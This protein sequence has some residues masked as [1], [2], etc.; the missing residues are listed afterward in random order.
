MIYYAAWLTS[1]VTALDVNVETVG[2]RGSSA[3]RCID[4]LATLQNESALLRSNFVVSSDK[5]RTCLNNGVVNER[6]N[7]IQSQAVV[8]ITNHTRNTRHKKREELVRVADGTSRHQIETNISRSVD[9]D[10]AARG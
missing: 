3:D 8:L 1:I 2:Q 6:K 5:V 10:V 4:C 9:T 7:F